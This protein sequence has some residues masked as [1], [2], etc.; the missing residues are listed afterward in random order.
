M[1]VPK[2]LMLRFQNAEFIFYIQ[3][4]VKLTLEVFICK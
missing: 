3:S 1:T 2:M 4:M